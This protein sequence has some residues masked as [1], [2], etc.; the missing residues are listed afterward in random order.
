MVERKCWRLMAESELA[1]AAGKAGTEGEFEQADFSGQEAE[2]RK[3]GVEP[4]RREGA[5][6]VLV[7]DSWSA[8]LIRGR[9]AGKSGT[10]Q[11]WS[12]TEPDVQ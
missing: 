11:K 4:H 8:D 12:S 1:Y 7:F 6:N 10:R 9:Q 2:T 5:M 3:Q